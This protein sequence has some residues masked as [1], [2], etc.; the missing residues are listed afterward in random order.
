[1]PFKININEFLSLPYPIFDVRSPIEYNKGHIPE[2]INLP[3]FTNEER[4][5]IGTAYFKQG[6]G[7]AI[8]I[9]LEKVQSKL[10]DFVESVNKIAKGQNIRLHCWRGGMRSQNMAWLL[11]TAGYKVYL[12]EGG[13]KSYRHYVLKYFEKEFS[14]IVIGGMTGVGKTEILKLLE[15]NSEQVIDFEGLAN[16]KGSVFGHLG[17]ATQPTTEYFENL[18]YN[19]ISKF[20]VNKTIFIEDESISIGNV[21][22]PNNLFKQITNATKI[23]IQ[24][25]INERIKRLIS[26][27]ACY[28]KNELITSIKRIERRIGGDIV[29][30]IITNIKNENYFDAISEILKYYDKLYKLNFNKTSLGKTTFLNID[31]LSN[32][33]ILNRLLLHSKKLNNGTN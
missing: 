14:F 16:H 7:E 24:R 21:F 8:K 33:E 11:E 27:Y 25:R 9:G 12:L 1:M 23:I 29:K 17:Q 20:S 3:L 15:S 30:Y 13:Y 22:I 32:D 10:V 28:D 26:E 6:R 19:E 5:I 31:E 18:I 2:A 4:A